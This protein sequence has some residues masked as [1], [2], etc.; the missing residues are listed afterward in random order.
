M[1]I[2]TP[3]ALFSPQVPADELDNEFIF[4][5]IPPG[6]SVESASLVAAPSGLT[7]TAQ[8]IAG[9]N[10]TIW[11]TGGT[12]GVNYVLTC[13]VS[14]VGGRTY[15]RSATLPVLAVVPS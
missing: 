2:Y 10:V 5:L 13:T 3:I 9:N 8:S 1:P 14:T 7:L 11:A 4:A 15:A 12:A 6:D